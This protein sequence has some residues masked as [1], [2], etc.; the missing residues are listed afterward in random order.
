MTRARK[1]EI[2]RTLARALR[3]EGLSPN[4]DV[5]TEAVAVRDALHE[6][7]H[8]GIREACRMAATHV[9]MW[10]TYERPREEPNATSQ[11]MA[12]AIFSQVPV[13]QAPTPE[14][15]EAIDAEIEAR[16]G[17]ALTQA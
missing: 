13:T 4:G 6:E 15:L 7:A 2:N 9:R 14:D 1:R 12:E 5:W 16:I 8:Y 3:G 11:E 10:G 17:K